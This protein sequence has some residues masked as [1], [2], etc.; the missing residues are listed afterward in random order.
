MSKPEAGG[1]PKAGASG[2]N[3]DS[4][5][6]DS[7][8]NSVSQDS[9]DQ[10]SEGTVLHVRREIQQARV[11]AFC[12]LGPDRVGTLTGQ[13]LADLLE[14]LEKGKRFEARVTEVNGGLVRVNVRPATRGA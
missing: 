12:Y 1:F 9:A 6:F 2:G 5:Q 14:C 13:E 4:L 10:L 7:I 11:I 3:C 8:L